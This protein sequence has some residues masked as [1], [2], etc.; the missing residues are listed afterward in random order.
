MDARVFIGLD[1]TIR[2]INNLRIPGQGPG[3]ARLGEHQPG[4]PN[5]SNK[6]R[7]IMNILIDKETIDQADELINSDAFSQF[8]LS[9][10]TDFTAAAFILDACFKAVDEARKRLDGKD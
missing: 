10:T 2:K 6:W 3:S 4:I 5:L 1:E 9:N 8:L 7:I